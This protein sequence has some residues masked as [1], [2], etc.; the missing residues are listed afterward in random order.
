LRWL[1]ERPPCSVAPVSTAHRNRDGTIVENGPPRR[2]S[3]SPPR[4]LLVL[5]PPFGGGFPRQATGWGER[6]AAI[7]AQ[8]P[9]G[10][11]GTSKRHLP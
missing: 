7:E 10:E 8:P 1:G 2:Q 9:I 3:N 6:G 4:P 11:G 5:E